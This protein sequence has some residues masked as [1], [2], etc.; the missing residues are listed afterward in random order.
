VDVFG[1]GYGPGA[2]SCVLPVHK[3]RGIVG[4]TAVS[5][6]R[7][8]VDL[9][10]ISTLVFSFAKRLPALGRTTFKVIL[11]NAQKI[12]V[13]IC[14][15]ISILKGSDNGVLHLKELGFWTLSIVQWFLKNTTFRKLDQFPFQW[16]RLPLC[17]G[18]NRV[19]ATLFLPKDGNIL[20]FRKV[21]FLRKH[22]TMDKVHKP[23][24]FKFMS[25]HID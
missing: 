4:L 14:P 5:F 24:S 11:P 7:S 23:N 19:G 18:P 9:R 25:L 22:W 21:V 3:R 13:K 8:S 12:E 2:A 10:G 1:P 16:L 17:K 6:S 20:S 15:Y